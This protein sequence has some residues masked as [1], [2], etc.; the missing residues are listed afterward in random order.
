[1]SINRIQ[2]SIYL[3]NISPDAKKKSKLSSKTDSLLP[4]GAAFMEILGHES[5]QR[6]QE[7]QTEE[8][9]KEKER[10]RLEKEWE[11]AQVHFAK[12]QD[13]YVGTHI[14]WTG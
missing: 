6:K 11:K 3:T 5:D 13:K 9:R 4:V 2:D 14:D 7:S 1:M 10:E 8:E 12:V